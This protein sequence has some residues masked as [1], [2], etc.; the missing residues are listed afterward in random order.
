MANYIS[1]NRALQNA[2]GVL[3]RCTGVPFQV[4]RVQP[5]AS[6]NYI[7]PQNL[8]AENAVMD[9]RP[10]KSG[11]FG[12]EG[13]KQ[14]QNFWYEVIGDCLKF[15]V[16]DVFV[17][18]DKVFNTGDVTV[19]Y[20][21]TEFLGMCLAENMPTMQPI[22]AKINTQAQFYTPNILPVN[23]TGLYPTQQVYD[24][25]LP[26]MLP[27]ILQ[28]GKFTPLNAGQEAALIPIG[29]T[30]RRSYGGDIYNVPTMNMPPVEKRLIY[31][32]NLDGFQPKA[33]DEVVFSD[34][35]R[36]RIDSNFHLTSGTSGGMYVCSKH[37]TGGG[38]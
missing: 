9:R 13:D 31:V 34:G 27:I 30:S 24:S 23:T 37:V 6:G 25:T 21:T 3:A 8:I 33:A 7:Q 20:K 26:N 1:I 35:S 18:N 14:M 28:N 10:M 16:G 11:N 2:Y 5:F 4:Y 29:I 36:Y 15:Q 32:P 17:S 38:Q 19:P 12:F 22:F